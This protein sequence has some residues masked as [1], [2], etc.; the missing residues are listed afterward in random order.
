[1]NTKV[2][3]LTIA[4]LLQSSVLMAG[5]II[6][7]KVVDASTGEEII[8]VT[9]L[10]KG[11]VDRW[12]VTGLDGSFLIDTQVPSGTLVC[13]LIGYKDIEVEFSI[14]VEE[15]RISMEPDIVMLDAA[16]VTATGRGRSEVAARNI[17]KNSVNVVNVMSAKAMELSPDITVAN[18]I[19]RMSGVTVERNSSGEGQYAILRGMDKRYNY[20]LV[21]GVK[22]PSP[23]NKNRFVPLDIFP[24]EMLDRI[25]VTKSLTANMEGDGIGGAV[26]LVMKDAPEK[27]E[28]TANLPSRASR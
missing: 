21:N 19:R 15:L 24:S 8:G 5:P 18:V 2:F 28:I 13:N 1:M 9:V 3:L 7:G 6:K 11:S 25:E 14:P 20:T 16:V 12:A 22:I 26:N 10:L 17:E 23:D 27:M 4:V